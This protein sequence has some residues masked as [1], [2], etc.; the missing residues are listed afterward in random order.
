M[1]DT[2]ATERDQGKKYSGREARAQERAQ[3]AARHTADM[4]RRFKNEIARSTRETRAFEGV[5]KIEVAGIVPAVSV[6]GEDSV[7]AVLENGRGR[8]DLCD[9]TVLDFA[10]FTRPGGSYEH[11]TMA[12]EQAL[13]AESYLYNVLT[14]EGK[15]YSENRRRN[16]NCNLFRN[17]ALVVPK[18]RFEREGYHSYADV[19][20]AAAPNARRARSEYHVSDETLLASMRDRIHFVL[21]VADVLG[22]DKLVLGAFG[23]GVFGWDAETVAELTREELASGSHVVSS[24][25]F[26]IPDNRYDENLAHFQHVFASFPEHNDVPF[27]ADAPESEPTESN[28]TS[29]D[30]DDWHLYL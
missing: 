28:D 10:S 16:L 8:A 7:S 12:Q 11:G 9:L 27:G 2:E 25:I 1:A 26:A 24:V 29:E 23:C 3:E 22:N 17:R 13:C 21:S 20:V 5:Q 4:E 19:I 18:V 15:W 14:H 6:V 30:E